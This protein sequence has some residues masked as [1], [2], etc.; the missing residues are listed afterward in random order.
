MD[1]PINDC[2]KLNEGEKRNS[3]FLVSGAEAP[4]AFETA[5][6]VFDFVAP[7]VVAAV[8]GHWPPARAFRRD[9]DARTLPAQARPKRVGV[10]TFIGDGT[11]VAQARQ[12]RLDRVQIVTLPF[13][14]AE[15]HSSPTTVDNCSK[16]S[17]DSTLSSTDRLSSLTAAWIRAVLMQLDVRAIDMP[18]LTCGS[19]CDNREHPGEEPLSTPATK[20][21]VDRVPRAKL[22]RR[23]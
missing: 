4:V 11:V 1:E 13:G 2:R 10:E 7:P 20:P 9:T 23:T 8:K 15:R 22:L 6:E 16:L 21:R 3:E 18:Q 17:I 12:K 14:Q 19:L 5:E